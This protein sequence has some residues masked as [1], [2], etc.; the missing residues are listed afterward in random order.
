MHEAQL[1][2]DILAVN[3]DDFESLALKVF[4]YQR[5]Y[6]EV[7]NRYLSL[8]KLD[9]TNINSIGQIPFLPITFFKTFDIRTGNFTP[10]TVFESSSTTGTGTSKHVVKSALW[11]RSTFRKSFQRAF[12]TP[13]DYCH[14]ALLPSYLERNNSSLVY[15]VNDFINHSKYA[16]SGFYLYDHQ[17]LAN[18]IAANEAEGIPTLLWGVSFAL[19][20]FAEQFNIPMKHTRIIETG[21]MKGRRKEITRIEMHSLLQKSF[22][23]NAIAGEYGMTELMSQAY[24]LSNG[25][26]QCPQ[27]MHVSGREINDPLSPAQ[28]GRNCVLNI[29]DLGNIDSCCFIATDDIGRVYEDNRFEVLGRLDNSDTRGC[30]LM[31]Q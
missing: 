14:L 20:D 21:G 4:Q 22:G 10:E 24:A 15:Q 17:A 9:T 13:E 29:I 19:L 18:R 28:K 27:W 2:A 8:L 3:A 16:Q 26:Y 1:K 7:Y 30:N 6:C 31:I 25:I 12:G 23:P 5:Q 11:Y